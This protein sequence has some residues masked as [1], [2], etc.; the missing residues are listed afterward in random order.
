MLQYKGA[1]H[2]HCALGFQEKVRLLAS[3]A[4]LVC[5]ACAPA[6]DPFEIH[7]Y[8]YE[9]LSWREYSL[10]AHLNMIAR[11]AD[12]REGTL[13]PTDG[14]THLTLEPTFGLSPNFALGFMFLNARGAWLQSSVRWMA[15]AAA[16][17]C[18]ASLASTLWIGIGVRVLVSKYAL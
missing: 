5:V 13:L 17:L 9:P 11:G 7:I 16:F 3:F 14:Q 4:C 12:S 8:E 1:R 6:Q 15:H 10:E 18:A 2:I